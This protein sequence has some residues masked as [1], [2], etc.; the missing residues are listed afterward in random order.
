[1]ELSELE[2]QVLVNHWSCLSEMMLDATQ[3]RSNTTYFVHTPTDEFVLK[4]YSTTTDAAQIEYEHSLLA[5]LQQVNLSFAIPAPIPALSDETLIHVETQQRSLK[6][7]LLPRIVGQPADRRNL[8]QIQSI[9]CTLAELHCVL[10]EFDSQGQLARLPYWGNLAQI[11][12]LINNPLAIT[13]VL[14]LGFAEETILNHMLSEVIESVPYL[15]Q[16][17]PLQTIHADYIT[18]NILVEDDQVIGVLDFEFATFDLRLLDYLSSLDQLASFPWKEDFF[19]DIVKAFSTGYHQNSSLISLEQESLLTV[20][21]VQRA[22][23]LVYWTGWFMEGKTNRQKVIDA[24]IET[25]K[26]ETWLDNNSEYFLDLLV[27]I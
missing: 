16:T 25:L 5:F 18:P 4:I 23:S 17:L 3:G 6:V 7:A 24:V 10:T 13:Q 27:V 11:H 2:K 19:A 8:Q 22:S 1:M 14:N 15:Y 9:G 26:F 12:P 20:W 21:R